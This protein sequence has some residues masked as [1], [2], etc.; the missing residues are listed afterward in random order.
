VR[1]AEPLIVDGPLAVADSSY[2]NWEVVAEGIRT[3]STFWIAV[4]SVRRMQWQYQKYY[5]KP[6]ASDTIPS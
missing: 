2:E 4:S 1:D 5:P 6:Y 3:D